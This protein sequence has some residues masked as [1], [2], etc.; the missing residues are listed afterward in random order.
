V[1]ETPEK[2]ARRSE[3]S[4]RDLPARAP[5]AGSP[6]LAARGLA[7]EGLGNRALLALHRSGRLQRKARVSQPGDS[8][9]HAADRAAEAAV[10]G[11]HSV[12]LHSHP[13]AI[14]HRPVPGGDTGTRASALIGELSGGRGLDEQT[15]GL[16]ESRFGE[17]FD[18]VRVHTGSRAAEMADTVEAR[19]FTVGSDIVFGEGQYAPETTEG[20]RLLA[21]ELAHVVQQRRTVG[22]A[23]G[24]KAAER[25]AHEAAR[26]V[27]GGGTPAVRERAAAGT[28]QR[29]AKVEVEEF[30]AVPTH[31]SGIMSHPKT[32]WHVYADGSGPVATVFTAHMHDPVSAS[33]YES[34]GFEPGVLYVDI[35]AGAAGSEIHLAKS[36]GRWHTIRDLKSPAPLPKPAPKPKPP[37]PKPR[38][39]PQPVPQPPAPEPQHEEPATAASP[40]AERERPV[41]DRVKELLQTDPGAAAQLAPQLSDADIEALS[42]IDRALLLWSLALTPVNGR[43]DV[44]T[45]ERILNHTPDDQV[46]ALEDQLFAQDGLLLKTMARNVK[47]SEDARRLIDSLMRVWKR[48]EFPEGKD[49]GKP[50]WMQGLFGNPVKLTRSQYDQMLRDAPATLQR[51]LDRVMEDIAMDDRNRLWRNNAIGDLVDAWGGLQK[52]P[53]AAEARFGPQW[54]YRNPYGTTDYA[55]RLIAEGKFFEAGLQ[56]Q[57]AEAL[58][59][60]LFQQWERYRGQ[61]IESGESLEEGIKVGAVT[62]IVITTAGYAAPVVFGGSLAV[63]G[64]EGVTL[65]TAGTGLKLGATGLTTGTLFV[66]G[67]LLGGATRGGLDLATGQQVTAD[68]LWKGF[69][70][71]APAGAAAGMSFGLTNVVGLGAGAPTTWL[72]VAK[73][74]FLVHGPSNATATVLSGALEGHDPGRIA[75]EGLRDFGLGVI[76]GGVGTKA[77]PW[78]GESKLRQRL[79]QTGMGGAIPATGTWLGGGSELDIEK[80]FLTGAGTSFAAS[81]APEW[82][83]SAKPVPNTA[84]YGPAD[85]AGPW[86]IANPSPPVGGLAHVPR[87]LKGIFGPSGK[88]QF[89]IP[90]GTGGEPPAGGGPFLL[91]APD[92]TPTARQ[93]PPPGLRAPEFRWATQ[94]ATESV[95]VFGRITPLGPLREG[96]LVPRT[97][98]IELPGGQKYWVSGSATE[99]FPE[100]LKGYREFWAPTGKGD[101]APP[102]VMFLVGPAQS[103]V[104]RGSTIAT[105]DTA[106]GI[107]ESSFNRRGPAGAT[108]FGSALV[109][110]HFEIAASAAAA[111]VQADPKL[112]GTRVVEKGWEF[113]FQPPKEPGQLPAITH[114][115][116]VQSDPNFDL[117]MPGGTKI[118]KDRPPF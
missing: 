36:A 110:E 40:A 47:G 27:M 72:N 97:F 63:L 51:R 10:S 66:G 44:A 49:D 6:T 35:S 37:K 57:A 114:A 87:G 102:A 38:P 45:V 39:G 8:A 101:Q 56:L 60:N 116:P 61:S 93:L 109:L 55:G 3:D 92:I 94:G 22:A 69:K 53:T 20:R 43:L 71:G 17:A 113:I 64:P 9:E 68:E 74:G 41:A 104:I 107:A 24:E 79:F 5:A 23:A 100:I 65:A 1:R 31:I 19:A 83:P 46:T 90:R 75:K 98:A 99:H 77:R 95:P 7:L 14:Q 21:H 26:E 59:K 25:D 13:A 28:V 18:E 115:L 11:E 4:E 81:F 96:T 67:G 80:A 48:G 62:I 34:P 32:S 108:L 54:W 106:S 58:N 111:R 118:P 30:K 29:Q 84:I 78:L 16:M 82:K 88:G 52:P 12:P 33:A 89:V 103:P 42:P 86:I 15:R 85:S 91:P 112:W 76:S 117:Q 105:V 50:R 70:T 73:S 2:T